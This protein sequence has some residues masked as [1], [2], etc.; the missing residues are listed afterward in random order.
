[1]KVT[2]LRLY[3]GEKSIVSGSADRSFKIWDITKSTYKQTISLRHSSTSN[4]IDVWSSSSV[5]AVSGHLDG[6][7]RIWDLRSGDRTMEI[8]DLHIGGCT[9]VQFNPENAVEILSLGR[10][11][12]LKLVDIRNRSVLHTF[13]HTDFRVDLNYA[14]SSISPDGKYAVAG[15]TTGDLFIWNTSTG[16]LKTKLA[17]HGVGVVGVT[18][19]RG[20]TNGQQVASIDKNGSL[21][22]WA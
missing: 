15:S 8:N 1:M 18:W 2:C 21:I 16:A 11:S 6:A 12:Q 13:Q 5:T 14:S 20:G 4:S 3:D 19:G 7:L 10:D 17:A 9:S 22:L